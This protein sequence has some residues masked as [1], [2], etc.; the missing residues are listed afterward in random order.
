MIKN[1]NSDWGTLG[2]FNDSFPPIMDGVALAVKNYA[3]WMH[4]KGHDVRVITP[5]APN[6]DNSYTFPVYRYSS[7]PIIGR[8][9]YRLGIPDFDFN[10]K[11]E[12]N[13]IRFSLVHAH[14]PFSS[15]KLALNIARKQQVPMIATFHSKFRDDFEHSLKNKYLAQQMT[16][17]VIRFFEKADEVWIPQA[18]VEDTIREYGFKGRLE[19]VDNG[20]D[21]STSLPIDSLRQSARTQLNIRDGELMFLFV[22]QHIREK[23]PHLILETLSLIRNLPFRMYF[24]GTGYAREELMQ[25]CD[26]LN[27]S[28]KVRFEGVITDRDRLKSYYAAADLFLFPSL[29]DNAPLVV[30]EAAAMHTPSVLVRNSTAAAHVF[31]NYN[32]FLIENSAVDF[33]TKLRSL[34]AN[35][36]LIYSTGKT[37]SETLARSWES[38]TEEVL[39]R[40][41]MLIK[42]KW[43]TQSA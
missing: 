8:E 17:E 31:D 13:K 3:H 15:G 28:D 27:L 1:L 18:S 16:R 7:V 12:L 21:F 22:G 9:P 38:I 33:A 6:F 41:K 30:R 43:K 5:K 32:G 36:A 37:A 20:N 35:K 25:L 11:S 4:Q 26:N 2:I 10:F 29:Y 40:Y 14:C 23:N 42:R 39:D 24:I 34:F 19:V